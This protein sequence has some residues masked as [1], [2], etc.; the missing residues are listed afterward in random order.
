MDTALLCCTYNLR[1][2]QARYRHTAI[3][4]LTQ[5]KTCSHGTSPTNPSLTWIRLNLSLAI[6]LTYWGYKVSRLATRKP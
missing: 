2:L 5:L 4:I 6:Q 3:Y 1:V